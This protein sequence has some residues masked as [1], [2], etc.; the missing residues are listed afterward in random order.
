VAGYSQV[1]F[2]GSLGNAS[3]QDDED[4]F[5]YGVGVEVYGFNVEYMQYLDTSDLEVGAVAVGYNYKFE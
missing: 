2:K 4:G 1:S 5:S 3:D